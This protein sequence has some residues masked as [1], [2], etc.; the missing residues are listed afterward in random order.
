MDKNKTYSKTLQDVFESNYTIKKRRLK[1]EEE[2]RE[3]EKRK[4]VL[5]V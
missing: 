2:I 1:E 5:Q 3:K 4:S